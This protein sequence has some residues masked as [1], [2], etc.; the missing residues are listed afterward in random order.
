MK[1]FLLAAAALV[2]SASM[3]FAAR[4]SPGQRPFPAVDT[5]DADGRITL[6]DLFDGAGPAFGH[7][8]RRPHGPDRR[9]RR[10]PGAG[11]PPRRSG[12]GQQQRRPPDHRPRRR[13]KAASRPGRAPRARGN[14]EV[15]AYARSLAAG[16]IVQPQD[17]VWVK[18]AARR[19]TRPAT[20]TP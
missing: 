7:G 15:L 12:L 14:V 11:R 16:E 17:L 19:R 18:M 13:D 20:P 5:T 3:T 9:A 2:I 8:R 6:G 10:R 4:P 1:A